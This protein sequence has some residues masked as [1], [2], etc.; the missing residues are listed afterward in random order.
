MNGVWVLASLTSPDGEV[1]H[2]PP[3]A[4][5]LKGQLVDSIHISEG[6]TTGYALFSNL[7]VGKS[8]DYRIRITLFDINSYGSSLGLTN[9]KGTNVQTVTNEIFKVHFEAHITN[10]SMAVVDLI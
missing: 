8:G 5:F 9:Q 4:D 3:D 6:S 10:L 2:T 7:Q 1:I